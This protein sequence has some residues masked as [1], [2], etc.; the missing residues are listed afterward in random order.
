MIG[1]AQGVGTIVDDEPRVG[2][3]SVTKNE[4]NSGTTQ[5]VFTVSLSAAS[6]AAVSLNF[7]TANG[8]AKSPEDYERDIRLAHLRRGPDQ[9]DGHRHRQGGQDE[10]GAGSVLREP[11]GRG[12]RAH[13]PELGVNINGTGVVKNDDR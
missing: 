11:L 10:R 8:S 5:F 13:S 9:Q 7:A 6:D 3:N 1:D 4:G 12:G 2:I